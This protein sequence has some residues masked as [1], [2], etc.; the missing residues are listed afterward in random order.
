MLPSRP[1]GFGTRGLALV[2]CEKEPT[3]HRAARVGCR[4]FYFAHLCD[5][6]WDRTFN[7]V[8]MKQI[9][10]TVMEGGCCQKK[11]C[12][13]WKKEKESLRGRGCH[14]WKPT[15]GFRT[16]VLLTHTP[17]H[18][19]TSVF[20]CEAALTFCSGIKRFHLRSKKN[21]PACF[22]FVV[23][24]ILNHNIVAYVNLIRQHFNESH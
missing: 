3:G 20:R 8:F 11:S 19:N 6:Q 2:I 18:T 16:H 5:K 4:P 12:A 13:D 22:L 9:Y 23:C 7:F 10:H 1:G 21:P 15:C 14:M 24:F 17:T